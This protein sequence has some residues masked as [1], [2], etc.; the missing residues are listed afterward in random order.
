MTD[1]QNISD[2]H[3]IGMDVR[4]RLNRDFTVGREDEIVVVVAGS[5]KPV[6][7]DEVLIVFAVNDPDDAAISQVAELLIAGWVEAFVDHVSS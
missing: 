5:A 7:L 6:M 4:P 2:E 1:E 3:L